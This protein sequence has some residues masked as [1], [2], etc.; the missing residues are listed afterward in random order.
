MK[1]DRSTEKNEIEEEKKTSKKRVNGGKPR[2][3]RGVLERLTL[4]PEKMYFLVLYYSTPPSSLLVVSS[5]LSV[6][7]SLYF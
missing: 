5:K 7:Q 4:S 2:D 6:V 1:T 3:V